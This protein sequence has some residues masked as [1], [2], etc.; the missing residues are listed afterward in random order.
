MTYGLLIDTTKCV[1]CRGC[2]VACKQSN[3][4]AAEATG[5]RAIRTN[6]PDLTA[7]TW[8]LVEFYEVPKT[9][10]RVAWRFV[11]RQCM[12]CLE[13]ACVSV[14]PVAALQRTAEGPVV[15][16][17]KRCIGCR[18]CMTACP[19]NVPKYEWESA[20]PL[21]RKCVMCAERLADGEQPA[22]AKA[23]LTGAVKFGSRDALL[24]E[25]HGRIAARPDR[26]V[27]H[28]YGEHEVGGTAAL[29][30]ADVAFAGIGFPASLP[31]YP[32]PGR[33]WEV[34]SKVPALA[35][36][37][38]GL[39]AF[40]YLLTRRQRGLERMTITAPVPVETDGESLRGASFAPQQS[41][42]PG[43]PEIASHKPLA[44]TA[45]DPPADPPQEVQG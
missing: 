9:G 4:L 1:G 29:Y 33:T 14:C 39:M 11:K 10:A 30:L 31:L 41:P 5:F 26:Y 42:P 17:A 13:P 28:V 25:A 36:G 22:C 45:D 37:A 12:H 18:Y 32:L 24:A 8:S 23:C 16:N 34:M 7:R 20:A 3:D 40:A 15:Y 43:E 19:F 27:S 44:M 2:Q 35:V 21:V 6:P 38:A